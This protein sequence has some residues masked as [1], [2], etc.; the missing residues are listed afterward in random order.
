M[1]GH[2]EQQLVDYLLGKIESGE[3]KMGRRIPSEYR[4]AE[5]FEVDKGTANRA[6]S[7]LVSRGYLKR[8]R[9]AAGTVLIR[10][11]VFPLR[12]FVYAGVFPTTHSFY[13]KL[14]RGI[15]DASHNEHILLSILPIGPETNTA[16]FEEEIHAVNP[17]AI[18]IGGNTPAFD[19]RD[20][21]TIFMDT[22]PFAEGEHV[23]TV[24]P[25]NIEAGRMMLD[26][27]Y[28]LGH[29]RIGFVRLNNGISV[30]SDRFKGASGRARE[31]GFR[32]ETLK[33]LAPYHM[34]GNN[35]QFGHL[36]DS[37]RKKYTAVLFE[38]DIICAGFC[39]YCAEHG[40]RI[41]EDLSVAAFLVNDEFHHFKRITSIDS[42]TYELGS[43]GVSQALKLIAGEKDIPVQ[44]LLPVSLFEGETVSQ[45][46]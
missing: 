10:N 44:E 22:Y 13:G 34:P 15:L 26:H 17:D 41:P 8:H 2:K 18:L 35:F 30:G 42:H 37:V 33:L 45:I 16:A 4:L 7:V 5:K 11:S 9:G 1:S 39:G 19:L 31:L 6:V 46:G 36:L 27:L 29:R 28:R 43:Y 25:N 32:L 21:P 12:H 3:Y 38:N 40:V 23:R 14:L 20:V 24:N